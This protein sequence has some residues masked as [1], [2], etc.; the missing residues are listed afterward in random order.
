MKKEKIT[1]LVKMLERYPEVAILSDEI[2]SKIIFNNH[3]MPSLL[4][5]ES[6]RDRLI[7]LDGWSKAF[8]MTG[9]RLGWSYWP[10][11]LISFANKLCV[12]DHSCAS[13]ISQYAG[14]E[15]LNGPKDDINKI[16]DE[17]EKRKKFIHIELNNLEKISCFEPGG[18]FYAF[19]NI[20]KTKMN[21]IEFADIALNEYGVAIVPGTSFGNS[22]NNFV[23]LSYANSMENIQEAIYRLSKI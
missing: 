20:S 12:N 9:W 3:S 23:R 5:Y 19:P 11:K 22:A 18:A 16:F 14:I 21:D 6:I 7:V 4:N 13:S 17:F 1:K 2:Y 8:C 10:K 15:A